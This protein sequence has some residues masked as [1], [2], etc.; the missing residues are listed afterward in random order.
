MPDVFESPKLAH[1]YVRVHN[2]ALSLHFENE[3][4]QSL[5]SCQ[6]PDGLEIPYTRTMMVFLLAK[7]NPDH[8]LMIGLGGGSLAKFC[9]KHL[10]NTHITVVEINPDVI[11][12]RNLFKVP[13][14]DDRFRVVLADGADFVR[15]AKTNFDV[16]LVDGFDEKGQ[17][18]QLTTREFYEDCYRLLQSKGILVANLDNEH[19]AHILFLKRALKTFKNCAVELQVP[20]RSNSILFACKDVPITSRWMSLSWTLNAHTSDARDQLKDE[21]QRILGIL[22]TLEA[23]TDLS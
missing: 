17:S 23:L 22:G 20:E 14:D 2:D 15:D 13:D 6:N 18:A 3:C 19:P 7:P 10:P 8:I 5:M 9:H 1:P 16:I 11:A 21:F 4:I 12:L